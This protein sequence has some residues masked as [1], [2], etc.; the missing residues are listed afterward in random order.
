MTET[1]PEL[2]AVVRAV[3]EIR[4]DTVDDVRLLGL[5]GDLLRRI[6]HEV[7]YRNE[8]KYPD[9]LRALRILVGSSVGF[10]SR[11]TNFRMNRDQYN[12]SDVLFM[13]ECYAD[14]FI[15]RRA[16]EH[17]QDAMTMYAFPALFE[18]YM[19][20]GT[21]IEDAALFYM[22]VTQYRTVEVLQT[23]DRLLHA[24]TDDRVPKTDEFRDQFRIFYF[25]LFRRGQ[26]LCTTIEKAY[27]ILPEDM[28]EVPPQFGN[29]F[30]YKNE[31]LMNVEACTNM[32]YV[33]VFNLMTSYLERE[34]CESRDVEMR[35]DRMPLVDMDLMTRRIQVNASAIFKE[36]VHLKKMFLAFLFERRT[37]D[38]DRL[39]FECLHDRAPNRV[40]KDYL[41]KRS[42]KAWLMLPTD[43]MYQSIQ[44]LYEAFPTLVTDFVLGFVSNM[45]K[46]ASYLDVLSDGSAFAWWERPTPPRPNTVYRS[47][48]NDVWFL[49]TPDWKGTFPAFESVTHF[50]THSLINK[51]IPRT[52]KLESGKDIPMNL[53]EDVLTPPPTETS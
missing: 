41:F 24:L 45:E 23:F 33:H 16:L 10:Q 12:W 30:E 25:L 15:A 28:H 51:S 6:T 8:I 47:A 7:Q 50:Y 44:L 34:L 9:R 4:W 35:I 48:F 13:C 49:P 18:K 17:H 43:D 19:K 38:M 21:R 53:F 37:T 2:I 40:N 52:I 3:S 42:C 1:L 36:A 39:L 26:Q 14:T 22:P 29:K 5:C 27:N 11:T 31:D 20:G 32:R 46:K